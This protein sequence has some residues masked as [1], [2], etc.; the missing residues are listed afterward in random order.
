[1]TR[2]VE[3]MLAMKEEIGPEL[4]RQMGRPIRYAAGELNGFAERARHM[5]S[6]APQALAD[7]VP[8]SARASRG[9]SGARPQA[10]SSRLRRGTTPI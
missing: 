5:I 1:M 8:S 2:F 4:T 3:A 7:I 9:S 6:I 10:S